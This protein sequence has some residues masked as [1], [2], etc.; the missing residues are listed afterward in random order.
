[1][2]EYLL[3]AE[4]VDKDTLHT[5]LTERIDGIDAANLRRAHATV[6]T[7]STIGKIVLA[8]F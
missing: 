3:P 1:M 4:L 2:R 5:T 6:E 7:G 8:G